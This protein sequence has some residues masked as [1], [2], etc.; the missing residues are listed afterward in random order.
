MPRRTFPAH[1]M[2]TA[3]KRG[4]GVGQRRSETESQVVQAAL[5]DG[6]DLGLVELL[7][8]PGDE[9]TWRLQAPER[10]SPCRL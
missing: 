2:E 6:G 5:W 4:L 1:G 8:F 10:A 3:G 7:C 9:G